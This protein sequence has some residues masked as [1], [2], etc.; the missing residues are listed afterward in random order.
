MPHTR[1]GDYSPSDSSIQRW[2]KAGPLTRAG[3]EAEQAGG[4]NLRLPVRSMRRHV[5]WR[6]R[7]IVLAVGC[8]VLLAMTAVM[9]WRMLT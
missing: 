6:T 7:V 9:V 1:I 3:R 4:I 8:G 2:A 5:H